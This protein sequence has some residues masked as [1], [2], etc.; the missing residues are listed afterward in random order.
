MRRSLLCVLVLVIAGCTR[1]G[2]PSG[3]SL[4]DPQEGFGPSRTLAATVTRVV[5]GD[6]LHAQVSG[7]DVTIR[8]IGLDTPETVAPGGPVECFGIEATVFTTNELT[9][10]QVVLEFDRQRIDPFGRTLAYLWVGG[11]LFNEKVVIGGYGEARTYPPNTRYQQRLDAAED[12][13]RAAGRGL[14]GAC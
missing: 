4:S 12:A 2:S 14:W 10:R 7:R 1:E 9:G 6:T 11:E 3:G 5:D 8:L 13:A